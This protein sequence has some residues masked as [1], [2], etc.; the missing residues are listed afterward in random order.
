MLAAACGG[1]A[2]GGVLANELS[3]RG[4][5][6]PLPTGTPLME[7]TLTRTPTL[8][9]VPATRNVEI[10]GLGRVVPDSVYPGGINLIPGFTIE[11]AQT[12]A[13]IYNGASNRVGGAVN[14]RL[15]AARAYAES[16]FHVQGRID[17][18]TLRA[19]TGLDNRVFVGT[20]GFSRTSGTYFEASGPGGLTFRIFEARTPDGYQFNQIAVHD[21]N[22]GV[23]YTNNRAVI[24]NELLYIVEVRN[25]VG[26][27]VNVVDF[28]GAC[29]NIGGETPLPTPTPGATVTPQNTPTPFSEISPTPTPLQRETATPTQTFPRQDT[30]TPTKPRDTLTPPPPPSLTPPLPPTAT[31]PNPSP[32]PTNT[33][34][35]IP[36]ATPGR[37]PT[38]EPTATRPRF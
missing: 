12:V 25:A 24:S 36:T 18:A 9:P 30:A 1:V 21:N 14:Q 11:E 34:A 20:T 10:P 38:N 26:Q 37:P 8:T 32:I 2:V 5:L 27:V 35:P 17:E 6:A 4:L 22:P 31:R 23:A 19:V 33:H 13:D 28:R 3:K 15:N 7:P 29:G 16:V